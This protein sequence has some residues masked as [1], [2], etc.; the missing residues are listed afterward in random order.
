MVVA[1]Q[2]ETE[3]GKCGHI[4]QNGSRSSAPGKGPH[5]V[6]RLNAVEKPGKGEE[7]RQGDKEEQQLQQELGDV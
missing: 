6:F 3:R 1:G 4:A 2:D 5:A 7:C